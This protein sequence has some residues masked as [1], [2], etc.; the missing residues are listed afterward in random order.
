M[1]NARLRHRLEIQ[2]RVP[3][4]S[5]FEPAN[6]WQPFAVVWA[7]KRD[8]RGK[9]I[10]TGLQTNSIMTVIFRTH[11]RDDVNA[12]HRA[13][14]GSRVFDIKAATNPDERAQWLLLH[15]VEHQSKGD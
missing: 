6:T 9:E 8:P 13:V 10:S 14:L 5:S 7:E 3:A 11:Y 12:E 15:C 4:G 1:R 2:R